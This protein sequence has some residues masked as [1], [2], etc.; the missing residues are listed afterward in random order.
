MFFFLEM[1]Y[2]STQSEELAGLLGSL[3]LLEDGSPADGAMEKE[4]AQ[5]VTMALEKGTAPSL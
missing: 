1:M 4:W 2:E 3:S 5:A